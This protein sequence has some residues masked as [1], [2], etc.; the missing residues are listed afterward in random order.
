MS[1]DEKKPIFFVHIPKTGGMSFLRTLE[2]LASHEVTIRL[3]ELS[4]LYR[5]GSWPEDILTRYELISGHIPYSNICYALKAVYATM[6]LL[7]SSLI[8]TSMTTIYMKLHLPDSSIGVDYP[9][10]SSDQACKS[11][12]PY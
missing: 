12:E 6:F 1:V 11:R 8:K 5:S 4:W 3:Q 2:Q 10:L 7:Y 9:I